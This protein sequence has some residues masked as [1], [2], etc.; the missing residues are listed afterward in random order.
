MIL[1]IT[2][3]QVFLFRLVSRCSWSGQREAGRTFPTSSVVSWPQATRLSRSAARVVAN[4]G[5]MA[6][7]WR[8]VS[9]DFGHLCRFRNAS[10]Q[11]CRLLRPRWP[12]PPHS[13]HTQRLSHLRAPSC[14][15]RHGMPRHSWDGDHSQ[16]GWLTRRLIRLLGSLVGKAVRRPRGATIFGTALRR[17]DCAVRAPP[18]S[19]TH[20]PVEGILV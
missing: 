1:C 17:H 16:Y 10:K 15:L 3:L 5:P 11:R 13:G 9:C 14:V 2:F 18:Q 8:G 19:A 6:M 7:S 12:L 4:A 20:Q